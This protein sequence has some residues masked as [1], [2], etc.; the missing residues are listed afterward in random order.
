MPYFSEIVIIPL[1]C[2]LILGLVLSIYS[3]FVVVKRWAFLSVGVSHAAFGGVALGYILG[4][5]PQISAL[6]F[7]PGSSNSHYFY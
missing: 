1:A 2:A 5:S 7:R 3:F 6:F 4:V